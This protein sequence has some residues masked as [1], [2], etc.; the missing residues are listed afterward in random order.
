MFPRG[1]ALDW[2]PVGV[3][4]LGVDLA[5]AALVVGAV[6]PEAVVTQLSPSISS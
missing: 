3:L 6:L 4:D 1:M 5:G 2:V